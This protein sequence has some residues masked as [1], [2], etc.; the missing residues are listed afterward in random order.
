MI[1]V[2]LCGGAGTRLWPL[3]RKAYPKQLLSLVSDKSLLQETLLRLT[4]IPT[5]APPLIICNTEHRFLIME[6]LHQIGVRDAVIMLEP[7]GKNTAPAAT[8]AALYHDPNAILLVLPADHL[9]QD[10]HALH[11]A[12]QKAELLAKQ[13]LVTFGI[14]PTH[15]ETGYGYIKKG[16]PLLDNLGYRVAQFTEKPNATLAQQYQSS[17]NFFWN[18]GMFMFRAANYLAEM[19]VH[20][21]DILQACQQ[22]LQ[23]AKQDAAFL[24]LD[25]A[26]FSSCRSDSIDYAVM[27][28]SQHAVVVPLAA[29]WSDIGSWTTVC[30]STT[31][32]AAGNVTRGD[33]YTAQVKNSY[34][35]AEHRLLAV[36]GVSDHVII[37]TA[38]AVLVAHKDFAQEVKVIVNQLAEQ[39]RPEI[40][41]HRRVYRPWGYYEI[42]DHSAT[43]C[44]KRI[45]INPGARLSL[46][47][48]QHRSEH[49]VVIEGTAL[50]TRGEES[51]TL[52]ANESTY[53]P[54]GTKHRLANSGLQPLIIIEVQ[55]GSYLAEDDIVRFDDVYGRETVVS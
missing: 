6:Q 11:T 5:L 17:G 20:A 54:M 10:V 39:T 49:W 26:V 3:S 36:V 27:E 23:Q 35:H 19:A 30:E 38:D 44:V 50:V 9:I 41:L 8:L 14:T 55:S 53:I 47:A 28:K 16:E 31:Q 48:H 42:L 7:S 46:Q 15:A 45:Q 37:E 51:F 4:N 13:H 34:L 22:T 24:H 29:G 1:P 40:D 43:A 32:D 21:P 25:A 52:K 18:S 12:V 2:I 33:V